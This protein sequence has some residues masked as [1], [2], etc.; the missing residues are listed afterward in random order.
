[1]TWIRRKVRD[2]LQ[3]LFGSYYEGPDVPP[4]LGADVRW[5]RALYPHASPDDWQTYVQRA[6]AN[7][8]RDGFT[9]GLEW[10]ERLWPGPSVDPDELARELKAHNWMPRE[11]GEVQIVKPPE[12]GELSAEQEHRLRHQLAHAGAKLVPLEPL[13]KHR[14]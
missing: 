2:L 9:R 6:L 14:R 1:M 11:P 3:R 12:P 13:R 8:Y 7:A 10:N 4:R 5:F